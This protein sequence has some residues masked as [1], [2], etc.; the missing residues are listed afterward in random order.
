MCEGRTTTVHDHAGWT[1]NDECDG[2]S[3]GDG[4]RSRRS[5]VTGVQIRDRKR[6]PSPD[7]LRRKMDSKGIWW[8]RK[9]GRR[10]VLG[11]GREGQLERV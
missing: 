5:S 2:Q 3:K 4:R 10:W 7:G 1:Q 8:E 11:G 6:R 9:S